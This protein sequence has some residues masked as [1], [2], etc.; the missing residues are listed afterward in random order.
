MMYSI[1]DVIETLED[2]I[3][4][5]LGKG[6]VVE[7]WAVIEIIEANKEVVASKYIG[8]GE[9]KEWEEFTCGVLRVDGE[10]LYTSLPWSAHLMCGPV[11]AYGTIGREI[12]LGMGESIKIPY[13]KRIQL[14]HLCNLGAVVHRDISLIPTSADRFS[15]FDT[16]A[17]EW[18]RRPIL[19]EGI[20]EGYTLTARSRVV[21]IGNSLRLRDIPR[22][23]PNATHSHV[24]V[25]T[26]WVFR[27][28]HTTLTEEKGYA[29]TSGSL[30]D[31]VITTSSLWKG[32]DIATQEDAVREFLEII[33]KA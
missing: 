23:T 20:P 2:N 1:R 28:N 14:M 22:L 31:I 4:Y 24:Y 18:Y 5:F 21:E 12:V 33:G 8:H 27:K 3:K 19:R 11:E 7:G 15:R 10:V 9:D 16:D 6:G 29:P 17:Y 30:V 13:E 25:E 26:K 32:E